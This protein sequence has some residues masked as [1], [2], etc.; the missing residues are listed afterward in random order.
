MD[1]VFVDNVP[2]KI[3][4]EDADFLYINDPKGRMISLYRSENTNVM[5]NV[6]KV[7]LDHTVYSS[8]GNMIMGSKQLGE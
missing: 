7:S 8:T 2:Y 4:D 1:I 6:K 3:V 5:R